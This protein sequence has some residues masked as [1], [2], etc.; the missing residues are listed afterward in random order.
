MTRQKERVPS[1]VKARKSEKPIL[2]FRTK[3]MVLGVK[4]M[5]PK[6]MVMGRTIW[7]SM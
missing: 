4:T 1:R 7:R 6:I 3:I 5:I 2:M